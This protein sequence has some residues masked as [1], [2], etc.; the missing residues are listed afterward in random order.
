MAAILYA[1][2]GVLLAGFL[3]AP[4]VTVG[5]PYLL[6][7]IAAVVIGGAS[8]TGGLA[9][10]ISTFAAAFFL[11]GL[12]QM[13]RVLTLPTASPVR[14][15]RAGDRGWDAGFRGPDHQGGGEGSARPLEAFPAEWREPW[16]QAVSREMSHQ[17]GRTDRHARLEEEE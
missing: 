3:R 10:P 2:A 15:V 17:R 9:S 13:M 11:A 4:G 5:A 7:P 1:T 14:G 8:L 12:N 16:S 6:G